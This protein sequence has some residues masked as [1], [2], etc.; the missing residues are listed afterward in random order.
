MECPKREG[1]KVC[2][3]WV[4]GCINPEVPLEIKMVC[5]GQLPRSTKEL[6][7]VAK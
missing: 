5:D 7:G 2:I 6:H 1:K 3:W 4:M